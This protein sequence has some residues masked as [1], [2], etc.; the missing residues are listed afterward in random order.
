MIWQVVLAALCASAVAKTGGL[1]RLEADPSIVVIHYSTYFS[2]VTQTP[3]DHINITIYNAGDRPVKA[4][5]LLV[6]GDRKIISFR[7]SKEYDLDLKYGSGLVRENWESFAAYQQIRVILKEKLEPKHERTY[8]FDL[9]FKGFGEFSPKEITLFEQQW[10]KFTMVKFV[11]S[12]YVIQ[13]MTIKY[14]TGDDWNTQSYKSLKVWEPLSPTTEIFHVILNSH[15]TQSKKTDHYFEIS[16]WGNIY[17]S[18]HLKLHNRAAKLAGEYNTI[19]YNGNR[20]D[21]GKNSFRDSTIELPK[22][23][24]GLFFRDQIGNISTGFV[25]PQEVVFL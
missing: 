12:P 21:T 20:K 16:H 15:F 23:A 5:F 24:F 14:T 6:R 19:E 18:E 2:Y 1:P 10:I 11:A 8:T 7:E 22:N 4:F 25:K 17:V 3:K 9:L 13:N